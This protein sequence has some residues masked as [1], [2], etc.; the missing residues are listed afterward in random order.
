MIIVYVSANRYLSMHVPSYICKYYI[1]VYEIYVETCHTINLACICT[2]HSYFT[3]TYIRSTSVLY[4]HAYYACTYI[5]RVTYYLY[6]Y[7]TDTCN[8]N[9]NQNHSRL[10]LTSFHMLLSIYLYKYKCIYVNICVSVNK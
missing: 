8:K 1:Y 6:S 4:V 9:Q 10:S 3:D 7:R 5:Y 2:V